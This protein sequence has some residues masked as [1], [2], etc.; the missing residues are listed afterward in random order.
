[1]AHDIGARGEQKTQRER[2]TQHPLSHRPVREYIV[3]E[4]RCALDHTSGA[5][6]VPKAAPTE[7]AAFAT[8]CDKLFVRAILTTDTQESVL[9]TTTLQ[10][11]LELLLDMPRQARALPLKMRLERGEVL[12]DQLIQKGALGAVAHIRWHHNAQASFPASG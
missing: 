1:M 6:T 2:H 11:R 4:Q 3:D 10:K 8:E 9:Q 7:T 12:L 5:A